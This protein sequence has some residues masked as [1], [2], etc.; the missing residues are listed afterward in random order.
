MLPLWGGSGGCEIGKISAKNKQQGT[1]NE[2]DGSI[3]RTCKRSNQLKINT[4]ISMQG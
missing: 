4:S 1:A 3:R 2:N